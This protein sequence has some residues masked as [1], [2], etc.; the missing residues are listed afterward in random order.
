MTKH[1]ICLFQKK[2]TLL[3]LILTPF[4][5]N[6]SINHCATAIAPEQ[7]KTY[8]EDNIHIEGLVGTFSSKIGELIDM[9][10]A[11]TDN[12]DIDSSDL[13]LYKRQNRAIL[14]GPPGNGKTTLVKKI[15]EAT[16]SEI[17]E[18][19]GPMIIDKFTGEG[20]RKIAEAFEKAT[21][22]VNLLGGTVII[23]I[24]EI[25]A[26][27]SA[28]KDEGTKAE[29]TK[30]TQ[31]FWTK[32][33]S[34]QEDPR[35]LVIGATNNFNDLDKTLIDRFGSNI[36]EIKNPTEAIR[37]ELLKFYCSKYSKARP[38]DE[39]LLKKIAKQSE[40]L[41]ARALEDLIISSAKN[42]KVRGLNKMDDAY[43]LKNFDI[44]KTKT[45]GTWQKRIQESASNS[46]NWL[47]K[48]AYPHAH[49]VYAT[50]GAT[51]A[52]LQYR[53][54]KTAETN[55]LNQQ[56]QLIKQAEEL[57]QLK[58]TLNKLTTLLGEKNGIYASDLMATAASAA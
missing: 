42:A 2:Q 6:L 1:P 57:S 24:D 28:L 27:S 36:I 37:L 17:I 25:D 47:Q 15:K 51:W 13:A 4:L 46:S 45:L 26:I 11:S 58:T 56:L 38:A 23:F 16:G 10:N 55:L 34:M 41:S 12:L 44:T 18:L 29:A 43:L 14:Y 52:Y 8:C 49:I 33:D 5:L 54:S 20:G 53:S 32:L 21:K 35:I 31:A 9:L 48:N 7:P 30:I 22:I 3:I 39:T 40:G 19:P 50:L